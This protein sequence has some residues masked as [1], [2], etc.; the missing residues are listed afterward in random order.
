MMMMT[1]K[2]C[3]V[4]NPLD[5]FC[6]TKLLT[7]WHKCSSSLVEAYKGTRRKH[8]MQFFPKTISA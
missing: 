6:F 7:V 3:V 2:L 1:N 5:L 4:S 8:K